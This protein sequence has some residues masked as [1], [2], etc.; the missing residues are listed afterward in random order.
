M[1]KIVNLKIEEVTKGLAIIRCGYHLGRFELING[2]YHFKKNEN[3]LHECYADK[4]I[5]ID[6]KATTLNKAVEF[7]SC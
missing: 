6:T 5:D 4:F 2:T 1:K 3:R 7:M